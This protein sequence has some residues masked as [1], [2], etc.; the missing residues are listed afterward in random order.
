MFTDRADAGR[1][2]ARRL[3]DL[4]F[5]HP[6]VL[7]IP[8]GGVV[9]GAVLARSLGADLDVILARK[10]RAPFQP[11]LALGAVGE[12]GAIYLNRTVASA[13]TLEA[14]DV[15]E[16]V[17]H[18]LREIALRRQLYRGGA[19]CASVTRRSVIVTDDGIATGSTMIAA[20]HVVNALDPHEV[21]V[22]T[23]VAPSDRVGVIRQYCDHLVYLDAPKHFRSVGQYYLSFEPVK[24]EEV[25][26]LLRE[27]QFPFAP[28][29]TRAPN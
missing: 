29:A 9:T 4:K 12:D 2:L 18:E 15:R 22:A 8:R 16:E 23:P 11:E 25:S 1:Q 3:A 20:L 19:A 7:A 17:E 5:H 14:D 21:I 13:L 27:N 10:L 28:A 6:I 26:R 24:D